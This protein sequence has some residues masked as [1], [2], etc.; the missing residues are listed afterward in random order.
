MI[1]ECFPT[2]SYITNYKEN[3]LVDTSYGNTFE[4]LICTKNNS[5]GAILS[6]III[7]YVIIK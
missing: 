4:G 5:W 7:I 2:T 1:V 6:T 3:L